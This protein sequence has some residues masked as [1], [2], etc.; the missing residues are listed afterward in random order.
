MPID[1]ELR[2]LQS[3]PLYHFSDWPNEAIPQ[4]AAG[5]YTIWRGAELMYVG[6]SGRALTAAH[7]DRYR[8]EGLKGKGLYSRLA[9]HAAG[10]RSGDQFCVYVSDRLVL[11]TLSASQIQRVAS[12]E[13]SLDRL[14]REYIHE[15]LAYR[16]VEASCGADA[17]ILEHR[18]RVGD[19]VAGKPFL[20]P[21]GRRPS[22]T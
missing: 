11:P 14:T 22:P 17:H 6:M 9:S 18:I 8:N 19:W 1:D 4:V 15:N 16:A 5:V 7:I 3:G 2:V 13:L 10:R 20:N 21:A 12:A